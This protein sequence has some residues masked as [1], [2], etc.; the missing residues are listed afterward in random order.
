MVE[1]PEDE[2]LD[3]RPARTPERIADLLEQALVSRGCSESDPM[4][5]ACDS[6][7]ELD[8]VRSEMRLR[9]WQVRESVGIVWPEGTAKALVMLEIAGR[10]DELL[11]EESVPPPRAPA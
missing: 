7:E 8:A 11:R 5:F 4:H 10:R 1:T 3:V 6:S 2:R 9:G